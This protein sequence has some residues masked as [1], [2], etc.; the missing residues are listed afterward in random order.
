MK[1]ITGIDPDNQTKDQVGLHQITS[2]KVADIET[3]TGIE[4]RQGNRAIAIM[5]SRTKDQTKTTA[6][7]M[8]SI[9]I[10]EGMCLM[11]IKS[12]YVKGVL[13]ATVTKG[14]QAQLPS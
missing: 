5:K 7:T 1:T 12:T 9:M 10:R 4:S 8:T 11:L 13:K 6:D 2:I 3:G 14:D